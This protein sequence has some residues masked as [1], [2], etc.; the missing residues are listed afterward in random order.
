MDLHRLRRWVATKQREDNAGG[1]LQ[2]RIPGHLEYRRK[3]I[4]DE[5]SCPI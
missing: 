1:E 2:R 4:G 3:G 5:V